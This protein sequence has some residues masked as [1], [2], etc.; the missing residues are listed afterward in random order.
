VSQDY[1]DEC[2]GLG[3]AV[4]AW[5]VNQDHGIE[6]LR[7]WGADGIITDDPGLAMKIVYGE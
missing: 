1:I 3:I 4:N 7:D 5:T 6:L 2:H